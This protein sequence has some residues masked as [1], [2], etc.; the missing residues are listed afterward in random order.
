MP[1]R[2]NSNR[3]RG[4]NNNPEG[5]NQYSSDWMDTVRERPMASAAAAAAAVGA[6]VFLWSKRN[7]ISDQI[8]N[9]SGQI[10]DWAENMQSGSSGREMEMAGGSNESIQSTATVG[11]GGNRNA[12]GGGTTAKARRTSG[13]AMPQSTTM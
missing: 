8:S 9:L 2:S 11:T 10:S 3:N 7:Q 4:R 5:R 13:R 6:G 1:Q 12:S